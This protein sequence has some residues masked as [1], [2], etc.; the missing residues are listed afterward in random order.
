MPLQNG[1]VGDLT[2]RFRRRQ[3][4]FRRR[5]FRKRT[6]AAAQASS[7]WPFSHKREG[8]RWLRFGLGSEWLAC[9][10]LWIPAFAGMTGDG[11]RKWREA[12]NPR[13]N[14]P[15]TPLLAHRGR[16]D[17]LTAIR[18][19][20]GISQIS[21]DSAGVKPPSARRR[22]FAS[23]LKASIIFPKT[24]QSHWEEPTHGQTGRQNLRHHRR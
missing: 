2:I 15:N 24:I 8:I 12:S 11:A 5:E 1:L 20:L 6:G 23:L 14:P 22:A 16:R 19:W 17:L 21:R 13:L 4:A 3:T 18:A 10:G 7:S 9:W